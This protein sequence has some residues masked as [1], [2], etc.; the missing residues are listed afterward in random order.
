MKYFAVLLCL[1]SLHAYAAGWRPTERFLFAVR[2]VESSHGRFIYGDDGQSLGDFQIS[3]AA[4]LDVSVWRKARG[5]PVYDYSRNVFDRKIN[6][7]Y[8]ADYLSILYSKLKK[9]LKRSPTAE[10]VYDASKSRRSCNR[11]NRRPSE[12]TRSVSALDPFP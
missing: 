1:A 5:F 2:Y 8:A 10:E 11:W 7:L 9:T 6:R 3:E 4:W 12:S